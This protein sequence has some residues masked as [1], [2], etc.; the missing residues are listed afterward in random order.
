MVQNVISPVPALWLT[1]PAGNRV[2][3]RLWLRAG[4]HDALGHGG[5]GW[6]WPTCRPH[7][8]L[9]HF[10][11]QSFVG[12]SCTV[13]YVFASCC[14]RHVFRATVS[15]PVYLGSEKQIKML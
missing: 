13:S 8:K 7:R 6:L 9:F 10:K 14:W 3:R 15:S 5:R 11:G 12:D 4:G 1:A 2:S